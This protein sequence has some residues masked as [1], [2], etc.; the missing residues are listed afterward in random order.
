MLRPAIILPALVILTA[1][2]PSASYTPPEASGLVPIRPYPAAGDVCVV[3]GDSPA[4][5]EYLDHTATLVACP[6]AEG[7]AIA[8]RLAEGGDLVAIAGDWQLI[9]IPE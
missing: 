3:V 6:L 9:S 5:Q 8:D 4:T 2:T 7:G 1:C